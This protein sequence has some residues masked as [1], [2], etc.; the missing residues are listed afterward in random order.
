MYEVLLGV[1]GTVIAGAFTFLGRQLGTNAE[2]HSQ[3]IELL[4]EVKK[5]RDEAVAARQ[6]AEAEHAEELK[7]RQTAEHNLKAMANKLRKMTEDMDALKRQ[8]ADLAA[9]VRDHND[10]QEKYD[11]AIT[12]NDNLESTVED[13]QKRLIDSELLNEQLVEDLLAL[14]ELYHQ[15]TQQRPPQRGDTYEKHNGDDGNLD[16]SGVPTG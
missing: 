9:E 6:K 1:G 16:S 2:R 14:Q 13:L 3:A 10:L 7:R 15:A 12:D 8:L 11:D 5:L 4:N